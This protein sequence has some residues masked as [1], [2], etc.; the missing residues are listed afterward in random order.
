MELG[1]TC[2]NLIIMG[3][4]NSHI[5]YLDNSDAEQFNDVCMATGLEQVVNF[6]T[7][8]QGHTLD[9]VLHESNSSI[10][11]RKIQSGMYLSDHCSV[12]ME[13]NIKR[14]YVVFKKSTYRNLKKA[15]SEQVCAQHADLDKKL[16][17]DTEYLCGFLEDYQDGLNNVINELVPEKTSKVHVCNVAQPWFNADLRDQKIK[18]HNCERCWTKYRQNH[19]WETFNME[20]SKYMKMIHAVR[21][22]FYH[23][24]FK[25]HK[26]DSK[27]LYKLVSRLTGSI[28]E[29]KVLDHDSNDVIC[30]E[31]ADF[32]LNKI[33]RIR[34][35]LSDYE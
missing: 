11:I 2:T 23:S 19:Q 25:L 24:K 29:N 17:Y 5:D 1:T 28:M 10:K 14:S 32:F 8:I 33:T 21:I 34:E 4:F 22:E 12:E 20:R 30:E 7:H 27:E 35:S 9:L 3:G 13:I 6:G 26:G 18:V 31:L 16:N 15:D